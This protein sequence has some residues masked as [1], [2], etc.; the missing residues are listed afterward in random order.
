MKFRTP[1]TRLYVRT[2]PPGASVSLDKRPIGKSDGLFTV[3]S[4]EHEVTL[5]LPGHKTQTLRVKVAQGQITR[6]QAQLNRNPR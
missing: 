4:G 6:V 1:T 3:P 5:E 2:T